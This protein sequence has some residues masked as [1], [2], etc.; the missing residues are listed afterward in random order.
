M[1]YRSEVRSLIYGPPDQMDVFIT[2]H[3]LILSSEV[4]RHFKEN[5]R[6]YKTKYHQYTTGPKGNLIDDFQDVNILDLSGD[7]WKWYDSYEDVK[8]WASL[9]ADACD[10]D[11]QYEFIR[12]GEG[13]GNDMDIERESSPDSLGFLSVNTPSISEEIMAGEELPL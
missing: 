11:L 9:L 6:Y 10:Q 12:I 4:F 1:G 5:L 7:G 8:S 13:D 2:T 3:R